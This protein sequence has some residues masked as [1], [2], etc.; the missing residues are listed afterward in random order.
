MKKQI[1]LFVLMLM[2]VA[3]K[4]QQ[5][6]DVHIGGIFYDI[7]TSSHTATVTYY[8]DLNSQYD[9]NYEFYTGNVI[10]PSEFNYKDVTYHV[11]KIDG[12]AFHGCKNLISITIPNSIVSIGS[13]AF[14][15]CI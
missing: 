6:Y 12:R 2:S 5:T 13:S 9:H 1:L 11:T 4:A 15:G 10:I 3:I 14:D 7:F 8:H